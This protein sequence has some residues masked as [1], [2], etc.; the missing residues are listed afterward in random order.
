MSIKSY[1]F[2]SLCL[3]PLLVFGQ[4]QPPCLRASEACTEWVTLDQGPQRGLVYRTHALNQP[5]TEIEHAVIVIHGQGRNADGYF[6]HALAGAFLADALQNTLVISPRFAS[7]EGKSCRDKLDADEI[8][9]ICL[10]PASWRSGGEQATPGAKKFNSF[11]FMDAI[12]E[13]LANRNTFQNCARSS[14]LGIPLAGSML[15]AIK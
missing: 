3:F 4:A 8:G 1:L 13:R 9:W 14:L 10:G 7:N 12:V 5:N 2:A 11:D 6:R 15:V